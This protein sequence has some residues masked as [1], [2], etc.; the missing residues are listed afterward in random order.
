MKSWFKFVFLWLTMHFIGVFF[1]LRLNFA[2]TDVKQ[3]KTLNEKFWRKKKNNNSVLF[4]VLVWILKQLNLKVNCISLAYYML[5]Y[6]CI[7]LCLMISFLFLLFFFYYILCLLK[8]RRF[9]AFLR[10]PRDRQWTS[11]CPIAGVCRLTIISAW[12]ENL[13]SF[14]YWLFKGIHTIRWDLLM[15]SVSMSKISSI[16]T[17]IASLCKTPKA[18]FI[19]NSIRVSWELS[20]YRRIKE[21]LQLIV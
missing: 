3:T 2:N 12:D 6:I 19:R 20:S 4:F 11:I 9:T 1:K 16:S 18:N 15:S 14:I 5:V 8:S 7:T 10:D 21:L 17:S 13:F